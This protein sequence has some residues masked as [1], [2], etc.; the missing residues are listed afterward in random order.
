MKIKVSGNGWGMTVSSSR[1]CEKL[2]I[3]GRD[4]QEIRA[5]VPEKLWIDAEQALSERKEEIERKEQAFSNLG[6]IKI[7]GRWE[8]PAGFIVVTSDGPAEEYLPGFY[9]KPNGIWHEEG[10]V[11]AVME[12][13]EGYGLRKR[14][15]GVILIKSHASIKACWS[16][17]LSIQQIEK[18]LSDDETGE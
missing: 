2:I 4:S 16:D 14:I 18:I 13:S 7:R 10:V 11:S 5:L 15:V 1:D 8:V 9:R 6:L 17:G 12:D 3:K